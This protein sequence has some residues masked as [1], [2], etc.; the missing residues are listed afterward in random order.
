ML[1]DRLELVRAYAADRRHKK[2]TSDGFHKHGTTLRYSGSYAAVMKF[3]F[4][5]LRVATLS[6]DRSRKVYGRFRHG[7]TSENGNTEARAGY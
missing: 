5:E 6:R 1:T 7:Q 2:V 3:F 4:R